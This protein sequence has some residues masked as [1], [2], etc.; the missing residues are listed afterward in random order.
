VDAS[1]DSTDGI[2]TPITATTV[3][4]VVPKK[5]KKSYRINGGSNAPAKPSASQVAEW[6]RL[7]RPSVVIPDFLF[8]GDSDDAA[9]ERRLQQLNITVHH[10][11]LIRAL[12]LV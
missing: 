6:H 4:V 8:L 12:S 3:A 9:N 2:L 7:G 10:A 11:L 1:T 5:P